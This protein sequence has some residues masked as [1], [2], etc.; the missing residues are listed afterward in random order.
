MTPEQKITIDYLNKHL[1]TDLK[2]K[3]NSGETMELVT[4]IARLVDNWE[5]LKTEQNEPE[6]MKKLKELQF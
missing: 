5:D 3:F 1:S 4:V 2:R 6:F